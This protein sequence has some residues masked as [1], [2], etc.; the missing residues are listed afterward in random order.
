[1]VSAFAFTLLGFLAVYLKS[2]WPLLFGGIFV[3][4]Y[5]FWR[6]HKVRLELISVEMVRAARQGEA[7]FG[8]TWLLL[9]FFS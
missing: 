8:I 5:Y 4:V 1:M 9:I 2:A 6:W 3:A 7:V